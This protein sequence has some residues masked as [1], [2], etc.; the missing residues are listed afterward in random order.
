MGDFPAS[1][2]DCHRAPQVWN[3]SPGLFL[4]LAP[5]AAAAAPE[6]GSGWTGGSWER[7]ER[8]GA[9]RGLRDFLWGKKC[10]F[11]AGDIKNYQ[12]LSGLCLRPSSPI[13]CSKLPPLQKPQTKKAESYWWELRTFLGEYLGLWQGQMWTRWL[14]WVANG[15]IIKPKGSQSN[16]NFMGRS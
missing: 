15:G 9:P 12:V 2:I 4:P 3:T 13:N 11:D 10:L 7:G 8:T 14:V 1:Q 6:L 5:Q 16:V